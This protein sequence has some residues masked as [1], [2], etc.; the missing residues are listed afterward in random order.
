MKSE[1]KIVGI[2]FLTA[3]LAGLSISSTSNISI[4]AFAE[5]KMFTIQKTDKSVQDPLP[6]H[7]T[8]QIIR[9]L[10]PRSDGKMYSG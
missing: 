2:L 8:H 1:M 9:A 10:P 5:P 4:S 6:G 3:L 7:E